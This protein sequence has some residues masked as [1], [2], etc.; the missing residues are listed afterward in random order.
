MSW[1]EEMPA[2]QGSV[3]LTSSAP[4][5]I[6][7]NQLILYDVIDASTVCRSGV[8]SC[9]VEAGG[10]ATL[11]DTVTLPDFKAYVRAVSYTGEKFRRLPF[12]SMCTVMKV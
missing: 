10:E 12:E 2:L 3:C 5:P 1:A 9:I 6:E 4:F 7:P 8:L 11:P